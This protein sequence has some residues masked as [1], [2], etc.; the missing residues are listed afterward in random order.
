MY[1]GIVELCLQTDV[2]AFFLVLRAQ[3]LEL[4]GL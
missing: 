2:F 4:I 3:D 1:P